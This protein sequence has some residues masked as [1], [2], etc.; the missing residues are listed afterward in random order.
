M[1]TPGRS[2]F[3]QK[4]NLNYFWNINILTPQ[5]ILIPYSSLISP[6]LSNLDFLAYLAKIS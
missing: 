3:Q 1:P 2:L 5:G 4:H 6:Y